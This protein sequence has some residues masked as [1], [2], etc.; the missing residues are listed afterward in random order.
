[1]DG[2]E[3]IEDLSLIPGDRYSLLAVDAGDEAPTG[4]SAESYRLW[5]RI[6]LPDGNEGWVQAAVPADYDFG[7]DGRPSSV[8]FDLL[9]AVTV[10]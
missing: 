3:L 9:P 8:Q 1:V 5:Y 10:E 4:T 2:A 6:A 7:S